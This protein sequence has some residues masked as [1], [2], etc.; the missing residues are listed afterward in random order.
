M[1]SHA[2]AGRSPSASPGSDG[3]A[4]RALSVLFWTAVAVSIVHYADNYIAYDSYPKPD[5]G[6]SPSAAQIL[7]A[8]FV[9]TPIGV[10]GYLLF[11]RGRVAAAAACLA[12][13]SLSGLVGLGHYGAPGM[14]DEPWWRQA[15]VVA[16]IACGIAIL[17]FAAWS[18]RRL[19]GA[20]ARA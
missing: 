14:T 6:P 12:V 1:S 20:R 4:L 11:R 3:R 9:L 18:A 19:R 13:Y 5:S 17:G 8:W 10:A 2:V 16:D 15:H 7:A